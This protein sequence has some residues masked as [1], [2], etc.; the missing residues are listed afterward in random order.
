MRDAEIQ[1][2]VAVAWDRTDC[3]LDSFLPGSKLGSLHQLLEVM[4]L[5]WRL[6]GDAATTV[7][8]KDSVGISVEHCKW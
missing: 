7:G 4:R 1:Q 6:V 5:Q 3:T 8:L 2:L